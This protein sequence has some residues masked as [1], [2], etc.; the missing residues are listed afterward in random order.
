LEAQKQLV[1]PE[2]SAKE[3][4]AEGLLADL[5]KAVAANKTG[6]ARPVTNANRKIAG[7]P[8]ASALLADFTK[9]YPKAV[10]TYGKDPS[11]DFAAYKAGRK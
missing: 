4:A 3:R 6:T 10:V 8:L 11:A 2:I 9:A 1:N 7:D 5:F